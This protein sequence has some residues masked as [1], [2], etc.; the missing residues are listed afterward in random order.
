MYLSIPEKRV[1]LIRH[2]YLSIPELI[3]VYFI[4][5]ITYQVKFYDVPFGGGGGAQYIMYTKV[6][7]LNPDELK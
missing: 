6:H 3:F 1:I 5:H 7:H 2:K 4:N